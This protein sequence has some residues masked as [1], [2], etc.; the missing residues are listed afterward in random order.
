M[1]NDKILFPPF[2][3]WPYVSTFP[4]SNLT[5]SLQDSEYSDTGPAPTLQDKAID[6]F[7][8]SIGLVQFFGTQSRCGPTSTS[9]L[10][11][12]SQHGTPEDDTGDEDSD[13][14][15]DTNENYSTLA[16]HFQPIETTKGKPVLESHP[17][18]VSRWVSV[19]G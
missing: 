10:A 19:L 7:G 2:R 5:C 17:Y 12:A 6:S 15:S 14:E 1:R 3:S 11:N 8:V 9:D 16:R 18:I 13:D 4:P